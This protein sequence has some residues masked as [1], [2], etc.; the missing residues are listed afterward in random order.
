MPTYR[1]LLVAALIALAVSCSQSKSDTQTLSVHRD[2]ATTYFQAGMPAGEAD[3]GISNESSAWYDDWAKHMCGVDREG[4]RAVIRAGCDNLY[5]AALPCADFD[6]NGPILAHRQVAPWKAK[7]SSSVFKNRWIRVSTGDKTVYVQWEDVGPLYENDCRYVFGSSRPRQES[8]GEVD[9]A[10]DISPAAFKVLADGD[11]SIG[12]IKTDWE[13]VDFSQV[14]PGPWR[15]NITT[16]A[17]DW[18]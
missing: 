17:P 16:A 15:E 3:H 1:L 4:T 11:L 14:P 9:S 6:T 5:Y 13:F 2:I 7:T 10:L 18:N 12:I 8:S